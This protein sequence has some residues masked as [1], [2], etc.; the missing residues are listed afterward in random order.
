MTG[1][2]SRKHRIVFLFSV[3][4]YLCGIPF[5]RPFMSIALIL[6]TANWLAEGNWKIKWDNIRHQ[7]ILWAVWLLY[8]VHLA[9]LIHTVNWDYAVQDL[10]IK[11]PLLLVPLV[12]ATTTPMTGKE[13]R[14]LLHIYLF[15]V[16]A[17]ALYGLIHFH[18]HSELIDK[19]SLA[20]HI[21]YI[22][23]ELN[24]CFA[25]FVTA[26]LWKQNRKKQ[27]KPVY[28]AAAIWLCGIT[29]YIGAMTA[30]S[31]MICCAIVLLLVWAFRQKAWYF[32]KLIPTTLL[33]LCL[34]AIAILLPYIRQYTH[35]DF[36][37]ATS[38]KQ[39]ANGNTYCNT[40]EKQQIE[41]GMY[42]YAYVCDKEL[43]KEWEKRS[44][45]KYC[46]YATDSSHC[47]RNGLI[48]YLNSKGL[49]KD[50]AG[51]S[52]LQDEE[53]TWI[54]NGIANVHYTSGNGFVV[55]FY[56]NMWEIITYLRCGEE[57]GSVPQR[58]EAWK[59]SLIAI[60]EHPFF[61]VG[62]GDVKDV[63]LQTLQQTNSPIEGRL[64][65]SHN[66]YLSFCMAFGLIG[67]IL[68]L[69]SLFYP[70]LAVRKKSLL[71]AIF[72]IIFLVSMLTDDPLERQDGVS[73]FAVFNSLFLFLLP[74]EDVKPAE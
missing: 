62:T 18:L 27:L 45:L 30:I 63:F 64:V 7:P 65:R 13:W 69:F 67:L 40:L 33:L 19:R 46:N 38:E 29:V 49:R 55:R 43:Q 25:L 66:Q 2:D 44:E 71:Y 9:G 39:T 70:P 37:F 10:T 26:Y 53:I 52:Q 24:L 36:D 48:R 74:E 21:S 50:S 73:F 60:R 20:V 51:L 42:V 1:I 8:S 57:F 23:F 61:G 32:R 28:A 5:C 58:I 68:I 4:L 22:R 16:C 31:M 12:F 54:E 35:T 56:E 34:A 72:S 41:N 59:A 14:G 3:A 6:M 47:I 11:L 15:A 17:S